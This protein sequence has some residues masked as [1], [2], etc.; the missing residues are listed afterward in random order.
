MERRVLDNLGEEKAM[1]LTELNQEKLDMRIC[2][3]DERATNTQTFR[4]FIRGSEKEFEMEPEDLDA[5]NT[6][7]LTKYLDFLDYL[8]LK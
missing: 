5:M 2:D 4:E 3:T 1:P 8:W 6:E 7:S